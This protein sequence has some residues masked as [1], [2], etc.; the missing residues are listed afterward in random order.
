MDRRGHEGL[1]H[2]VRRDRPPDVLAH[3]HATVEQCALRRIVE[4]PVLQGHGLRV[5]ARHGG[6]GAVRTDGGEAGRGALE[7]QELEE[8]RLEERRFGARGGRSRRA[9]G[10][11]ARRGTRHGQQ[12]RQEA[13]PQEQPEQESPLPSHAPATPRRRLWRP[14]SESD[15]QLIKRTARPGPTCDGHHLFGLVLPRERLD[16]VLALGRGLGEVAVEVRKTYVT[17]VSLRPMLAVA[18]LAT[19]WWVGLGLGFPG[20]EPPGR[21]ARASGVGT[22]AI[23]REWA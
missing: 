2:E 19:T 21:L 13:G 5:A 20:T 9:D 12:G 3:D 15:P 14:R 1:V 16:A 18:K 8:V 17:L 6:Q 23:A 22:D 10:G 4:D 7:V 11:V